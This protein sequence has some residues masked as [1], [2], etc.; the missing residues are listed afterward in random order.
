[1]IPRCAPHACD[2]VR[3][4]RPIAAEPPERY[5]HRTIHVEPKGLSATPVVCL[6]IELGVNR[7]RTFQGRHQVLG[8]HLWE[9]GSF[10]SAWLAGTAHEPPYYWK[11]LTGSMTSFTKTTMRNA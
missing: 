8:C 5:R 10:A 7:R 9:E 11:G 1:M 6:E 4:S 2:I 3:V